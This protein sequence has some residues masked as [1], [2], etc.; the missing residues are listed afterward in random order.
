MDAPTFLNPAMVDTQVQAIMASLKANLTW[1][2]VAFGRA[3]RITRMIGDKKYHHPAIYV[4]TQSTGFK[5][6]YLEVMPDSK[7]GNFS[8]FYMLEPQTYAAERFRQGRIKA[9]FALIFWFDLRKVWNSDTNRDTETL[10]AQIFKCLNRQTVLGHN[11]TITIA[12]VYETPEQIYK[13]FTV[14]EVENQFLMH[15]YAG[16]RFEGFLIFDE[17]C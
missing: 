1:L 14:D 17:E 2:D 11:G 5:N 12:R 3:Q 6:E 8:F 15:P 4:G 7:I 13:E 16:F 9:P 10:K